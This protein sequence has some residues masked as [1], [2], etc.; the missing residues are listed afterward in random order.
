LVLRNSQLEGI[1]E[2]AHAIEHAGG[3]NA[4]VGSK[5][6]PRKFAAVVEMTG[7]HQSGIAKRAAQSRLV[8]VN[9]TKCRAM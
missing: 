2:A 5:E 4:A 1:R 7:I 6:L 8:A 9:K 3:G